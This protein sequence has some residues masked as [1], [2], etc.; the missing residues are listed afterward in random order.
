MAEFFVER[1]RF[2]Q[3]IK[4]AINFDTLKALFAQLGEFF[5]VL[6]LPVAHNG[7]Q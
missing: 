3:I 2:V 6:A 7:C 5:A 4:L 1:R